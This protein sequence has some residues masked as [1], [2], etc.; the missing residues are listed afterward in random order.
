MTTAIIV[1]VWLLTILAMGYVIGSLR[2]HVK[3]LKED[4]KSRQG[5]DWYVDMLCRTFHVHTE[6]PY[7]YEP[8]RSDLNKHCF[9]CHAPQS[10]GHAANCIWVAVA[11]LRKKFYNPSK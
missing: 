6:D 7:V 4:L 11:P 3:T 5:M 10:Y 2:E 1:F 9:H 8:G